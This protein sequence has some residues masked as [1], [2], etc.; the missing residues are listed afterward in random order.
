MN[1]RQLLLAM[2]SVLLAA[3]AAVLYVVQASGLIAEI[4]KPVLAVGSIGALHLANTADRSATGASETHAKVKAWAASATWKAAVY[5]FVAVAL[6][7]G[8]AAFVLGV[9]SSS[10]LLSAAGFF[11]MITAIAVGLPMR[12]AAERAP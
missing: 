5:W 8:L 10:R 3:G 4:L 6:F 1:T 12:V 9:S 2:L 11:S 7:G